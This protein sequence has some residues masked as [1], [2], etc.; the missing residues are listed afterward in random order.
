MWKHGRIATFV[1]LLLRGSL[2]LIAWIVSQ[3]PAT[4][5]FASPKF[6]NSFLLAC[7]WL[8]PTLLTLI[9]FQQT[10]NFQG[11]SQILVFWVSTIFLSAV[12]LDL[13]WRERIKLHKTLWQ[14]S[15]LWIP[16]D[17]SQRNVDRSARDHVRLSVW[18]RSSIANIPSVCQP[19]FIP[20]LI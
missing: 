6:C 4:V 13:S 10:L 2:C 16:I 7:S 8:Y 20:F 12:A 11:F 14:E 3:S 18:V 5:S 1:S 17:V 19:Y 9:L 15:P